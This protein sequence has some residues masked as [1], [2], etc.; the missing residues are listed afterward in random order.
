[1]IMGTKRGSAVHLRFTARRWRK[2]DSNPDFSD[3]KTC[4][5]FYRPWSKWT[6]SPTVGVALDE[7]KVISWPLKPLP[8]VGS[9]EV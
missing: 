4:A 6:Y 5:L 8:L 7:G 2:K 9:F 1:M 3:F